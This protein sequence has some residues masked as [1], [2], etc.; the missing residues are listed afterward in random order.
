QTIVGDSGAAFTEVPITFNENFVVLGAQLTLNIQHSFDPDLEAW[1]VSPTGTTVKL[2]QSVGNSASHANFTNTT[3]DDDPKFPEIHFA[4]PP[5][6]GTFNPQEP[7]SA[8]IG[9]GSQGDWI[10]R[11]QNNGTIDGALLNWSLSLTQSVPGSGLG[12]P[13]ADQATG[14]FRI[15][16]MDDLNPLSHQTWTA[17]GPASINGNGNSGR[18]GGIAIDPSDPSRNTEHAGGAS[19][20]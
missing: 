2:F 13:V 4:Q 5:F 17:V 10:L 9:E 15:F 18:I 8:F 19:G 20:G 14:T 12:E 7:L 11:I 6:N 16:T 1:L 3:F